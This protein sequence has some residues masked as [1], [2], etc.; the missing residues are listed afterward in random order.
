MKSINYSDFKEIKRINSKEPNTDKTH[1]S[2]FYSHRIQEDIDKKYM[3]PIHR[4]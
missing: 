4:V 1:L 2:D 3:I